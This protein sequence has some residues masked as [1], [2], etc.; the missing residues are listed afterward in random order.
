MTCQTCVIRHM[1]CVFIRQ[2]HLTC[3]WPWPLLSMSLSHIWYIRHPFSITL[4]GFGRPGCPWSVPCNP[5]G[6]KSQLRFFTWPWSHIWHFK[7]NIKT[8]LE[9]S[10]RE[11]SKFLLDLKRSILRDLDRAFD[12]AAKVKVTSIHAANSTYAISTIGC[13]L[14]TTCLDLLKGTVTTRCCLEQHLQH[15]QA[16]FKRFQ[17]VL[18]HFEATRDSLTSGVRPQC[19]LASGVLVHTVRHSITPCCRFIRSHCRPG[20]HSSEKMSY[21]VNVNVHVTSS[22]LAFKTSSYHTKKLPTWSHCHPWYSMISNSV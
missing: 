15:E 12:R 22:E 4:A 21:S 8:A 9:Y 3:I 1:S 11:L 2:P 14:H 7:E 5:Q 10:R 6:E 13:M 16:R 17:S 18:G 20:S 19:H